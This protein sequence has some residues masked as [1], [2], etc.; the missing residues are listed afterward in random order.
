MD[1]FTCPTLGPLVPLFSISGDISS[2]F[3]NQ[4]WFCFI[5][6]VEANVVYIPR[7]PPLV[8]HVA[9]LLM[10]SI[11]GQQFKVMAQCHHMLV[12]SISLGLESNPSNIQEHFTSP[13]RY[14][15]LPGALLNLTCPCLFTQ[16]NIAKEVLSW[17]RRIFNNDRVF[18]LH[19]LFTPA[20]KWL[21]IS[22]LM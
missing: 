11:V 15:G 17:C 12:H 9:N 14:A 1:T 3:Q 16:W 18:G 22:K 7:D 19:K 8:L 4:G 20:L 2:G 21:C 10:V 5:H 13:L 6:I